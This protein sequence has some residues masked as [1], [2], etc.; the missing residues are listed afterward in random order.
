MVEV[1]VREDDVRDILCAISEPFDLSERRLLLIESRAAQHVEEERAQSSSWM[2]D[3]LHAVPGVDEN[4]PLAELDQQAV[5]REHG[6]PLCA[7][8]TVHQPPPGRAKRHAVQMSDAGRHS[9][10]PPR[11]PWM[12]GAG[13]RGGSSVTSPWPTLR[14]ARRASSRLCVGARVRLSFEA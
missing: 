11:R 6:G 1:E 10:Q 9:R 8:A 4:E 12:Q 5:A 2:S 3:V 7:F 13:Q 14:H